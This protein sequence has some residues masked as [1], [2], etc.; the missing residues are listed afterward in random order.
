MHY[1]LLLPHYKIIR[2]PLLEGRV[3]PFLGA[4]VNLSI[5]E[6]EEPYDPARHLPSGGELADYLAQNYGFPGD[7]KERDLLRVSQYVAIASGP[8]ELRRELREL[9]LR[10]E[11]PVTPVHEFLARLPGI[12]RDRKTLRAGPDKPHAYP[13]GQRPL[14]C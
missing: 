4:G 13:Q 6:E 7:A 11:F 2:R 10:T 12:M 9:L 14:T 8:N 1:P 5:R 3:I